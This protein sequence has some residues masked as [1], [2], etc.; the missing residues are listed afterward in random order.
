MEEKENITTKENITKEERQDKEKTKEGENSNDLQETQSELTASSSES[1]P[2]KPLITLENL[3]KAGAHFGHKKDRWNPKMLPYIFCER[4]GI[5][6]I[7]LDIT[8]EKW[9]EAEKFIKAQAAAGETFLFVGTKLQAR[10]IIEQEAKRCGAFWVNTRWLGGTLSNLA[11]VRRSVDK[12]EKLEQLLEKAQSEDGEVKLQKKEV[13]RLTRQLEKLSYTLEGIRGMKRPPAV[14]FIVDI[15]REDIAVR[16]ARKLRIPIVALVD[17]NAD[18][19]LVDYPI[20]TN[21]DSKKTIALF[22]QAVSNAV[23][24]GKKEFEKA[25]IEKQEEVDVVS[26]GKSKRRKKREEIIV[27]GKRRE[28]KKKEEKIEEEKLVQETKTASA[29]EIAEEQRDEKQRESEE[30]KE[31]E[32]SAEQREGTIVG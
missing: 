18:P 15:K 30:V 31:E 6:I 1:L 7:N 12:M 16:E 29:E 26:D 5:H 17:T 20:P 21:D 28:E 14:V 9:A 8:L 23:L 2:N 10:E 24:E 11:T 32:K 4:N 22:V 13:L 25:R 19:E 27:K 3:L